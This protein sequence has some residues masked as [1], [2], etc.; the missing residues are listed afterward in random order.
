MRLSMQTCRASSV[1]Q[2]FAAASLACQAV[3]LQQV[4]R[5]VHP[6]ACGRGDLR[7]SEAWRTHSVSQ[8][9]VDAAL[10]AR[11]DTATS[12][13]AREVGRARHGEESCAATNTP[14][15][16]L[17][18]AA[19]VLARGA[20]KA[21]GA[22]VRQHA[23]HRAAA[24]RGWV[25]AHGRAAV[26]QAGLFGWAPS[27]QAAALCGGSLRAT[28][29]RV[30]HAAIGQQQ[31]IVEQIYQKLE[32]ITALHS[33]VDH[34]A[35]GQQQ[36]IVEQ[37][38]QKLERITALHSLVDH[39]AIGQQQQIVEQIYQKLER[40]TALHSLVD[41]AAIRQQQQVVKQV[42]N[43]GRR[44]QQADQKGAL[45]VVHHAPAQGWRGG[46]AERGG[47][48]SRL[49]RANGRASWRASQL[50]PAVAPRSKPAA[51]PGALF[52]PNHTHSHQAG[53]IRRRP[54]R[55]DH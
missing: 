5:R 49:A 7:K 30:D 35:I 4:W 1:E 20:H 13:L 16:L 36:Q 28:L 22:K 42:D 52:K 23:L 12:L 54:E 31:Q 39:A 34:A 38:Y 14:T 47:V 55:A 9:R 11:V 50:Q 10:H 41:H 18:E 44:L 53:S 29:S 48:K 51:F 45:Q 17:Q 6:L 40:I 46:C 43:L 26:S 15:H 32:R 19:G 2:G 21:Q 27:R 24:G 8:H 37:I 33:L 3:L 25:G